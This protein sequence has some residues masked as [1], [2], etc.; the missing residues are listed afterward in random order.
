MPELDNN[1]CRRG[2]GIFSG[3][4][5]AA[6]VAATLLVATLLLLGFFIARNRK[7]DRFDNLANHNQPVPR[8]FTYK[9]LKKATKNFSR[10]ELLGS[11]RSGKVN[12]G[13]LPS[14]ALVAFKRLKLDR[15]K[16]F[17]AEIHSLAEIE[18]HPNLVQLM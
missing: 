15:E 16:S 14:G 17:R 8:E 9:E 6:A 18:P 12:K 4:I 7:Q 11:G 2:I 5:S 13:T 1:S 3:V 10:S